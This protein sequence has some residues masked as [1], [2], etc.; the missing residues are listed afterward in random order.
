MWNKSVYKDIYDVQKSK[1]LNWIT[2]YFY[3]FSLVISHNILKKKKKKS[4]TKFLKKIVHIFNNKKK[5][6]ITTY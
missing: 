2:K 1:K 4:L 6:Y 5:P 3:N